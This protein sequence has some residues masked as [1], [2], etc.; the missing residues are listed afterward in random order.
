MKKVSKILSVGVCLLASTMAS[1]A[2][3][4]LSEYS[5]TGTGRA[6]AGA[7]VMG[8]DFSAIGFNPAGMSFNK[9]NGIQLGGAVV[10]LHSTFK[11]K[12]KP[13]SDA[14]RGHTNIAR[15]LPSGFVQYKLNDKLTTGLGVYVP[16][17]L[18][19][20]YDKGWFGADH[21]TLTA[22]QALNISPAFS[23]QIND[24]F[25][26][27]GSVNLQ[28]FKAH[29]KSAS[30]DI[31]GDDWGTGYTIGLTMK[32]V[33]TVRLGLSYRSKINHHLKGD[34]KRL[35]SPLGE[36]SGSGSANITTPETALLSAA[37]DVNDKWTL[38]GTARYTH[39]SRFD[40]LDIKSPTFAQTI[41]SHLGTGDTVSTKEHWRNT[42]FY[43]LGA[44]YK[45]CKN[46]TF[47]GGL[48][49]DM[50]VIRD[51]AHR[52]PRI[53]DGR[54]VLTSLGASYTFKNMQLD[55]GYTHI[56]VKGGHARGTDDVNK[57]QGSV[58]DIKY[59]SSADIVGLGFQYKF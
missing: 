38:S 48:G 51:Q 58:P 7:G 30:S 49:Y 22:V 18:A 33:D 5:A 15:A 23:Y 57:K 28:Q 52:T 27:G 41:G 44:D 29:L 9:T 36:F 19:T 12:S 45:Y 56:I 25:T 3:Y 35:T 24:M 11:G 2:G 17:G 8:D 55:F 40:T 26:I 39:W 21:G 13:T 31:E 42:G 54:R 34:L 32:P 43:A 37:W 1:A 59:N 46:L 16:F 20:N 14:G 4:Q 50:T 10:R 47:R 6:Y 53:P